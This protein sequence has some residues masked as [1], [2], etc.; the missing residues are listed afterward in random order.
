[1]FSRGEAA[2]VMVEDRLLREAA[3]RFDGAEDGAAE[4]VIFPE[5][6]G[7]GLVYK[8]V[9][10]VLIHLDLFQ[11]DAL[12]T[13]QIGLRKLWMQHQVAQDIERWRHVLVED[14][15]VEA[16]G[17]LAGIG[18]EVAADGSR[19]LRGAMSCAERL[20]VPLKTMCSSE[21]GEAVFLG[22]FV[23]RAGV[24]PGTHGNGAHVRHGLGKDEQAV[25]QNRPADVARG[26]GGDRR[27]RRFGLDL[28]HASPC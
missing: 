8:I 2:A 18:V 1:M 10:V 23:A 5:V 12:L 9:G 25:G 13:S 28:G 24:D 19:P 20:V 21:V 7:E 22:G 14:L 3:D 11:D 17:L 6:L 16:D 15:D 26:M 27:C 4:G